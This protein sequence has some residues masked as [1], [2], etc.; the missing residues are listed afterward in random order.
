[1]VDGSGGEN[2]HQLLR[3]KGSGTGFADTDTVGA[4]YTPAAGSAVLVGVDSTPA[5][6]NTAL[7]AIAGGTLPGQVPGLALI[8]GVAA[9]EAALTAYETSNTATVDALV[10]TLAASKFNTATKALAA[11]ATYDQ[12][13]AAIKTDADSA[14]AAKSDTTTVL[15]AKAKDAA[16]KVTADKAAL[17][18]PADKKLVAA[19]DAAVAANAALKNASA[20]DVGAAQ[21][22][23]GGDA[24]FTAALTEVNKV[25][26][27]SGAVTGLTTAKQVY[28]LYVKAT[29]TD[30]DRALLDTALKGD[31]YA[32]TTTFKATAATD[33]AKNAAV[34]AEATAKTNVDD[35]ANTA[36]YSTDVKASTDAAALVTAAQAADT[37]QAAADAIAKAQTA[38]EAKVL[39]AEKAISDFNLANTA[40]K[41]LDQSKISVNAADEVKQTFYFDHKVTGADDYNF[42]SK[43]FAAGDSIVLDSSLTFNSGALS[44]GN[45]NAAE[46]FLI[47]GK[48]GVQL[49]VESTVAGSTNATTATDGTV[50]TTAGATDTTAV[51]TLT[52]VTLDHVSVANGVVSYV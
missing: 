22:G 52:G 34:A 12:K 31:A 18:L 37:N 2:D 39:A 14:T 51:I 49:V 9:A 24:G 28:E 19:Y 43:A 6:V 41:I 40:S 5:S 26:L 25:T 27:S 44:A 16:D 7:A 36:T 3:Y 1:M 35:N 13:L 42:V 38:E 17:T 10:S 8:N 29:T 21:G 4:D 46:F 11:D 47:Q 45:N 48:T 30:A 50:T 32:S 20:A 15:T 23:L 33:V